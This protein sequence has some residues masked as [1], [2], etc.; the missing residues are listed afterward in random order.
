MPICV[1]RNLV[2]PIFFLK[3]ITTLEAQLCQIQDSGQMRWSRILFEANI[4]RSLAQGNDMFLSATLTEV[5]SSPSTQTRAM[6]S[7]VARF[8]TKTSL[9]Q[10]FFNGR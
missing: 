4:N 7:L 1:K 6:D 3:Y 5:K 10:L 2:L 8:R 9:M